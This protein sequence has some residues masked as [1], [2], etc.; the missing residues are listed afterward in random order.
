MISQGF[1][2]SSQLTDHF[3]RHGSVLGISTEV[4]YLERADAFCAGTKTN[5]IAECIRAREG[6]RIRYN[7]RTEEYGVLRADNVI[8]TYYKLT[9]AITICG[10]GYAYFIGECAKT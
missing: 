10:S 8:R 5:E 4:E 7:G 2:S 1:A 6:D 9:D 3:T